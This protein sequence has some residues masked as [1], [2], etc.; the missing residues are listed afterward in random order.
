MRITGRVGPYNVVE[1]E[2]KDKVKVVVPIMKGEQ[3]EQDEAGIYLEVNKA[4]QLVMEV[5]IDPSVVGRIKFSGKPRKELP[6]KK[7]RKKKFWG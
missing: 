1:L 3:E 2:E 6:E 5:T 4:G 7:S